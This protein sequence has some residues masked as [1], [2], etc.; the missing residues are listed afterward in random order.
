MTNNAY[1]TIDKTDK[2]VSGGARPARWG[3]ALIIGLSFIAALALVVCATPIFKLTDIQ[4]SGN[5]YYKKSAIVDKS[6]LRLGQNGL[7]ALRGYNPIKIFSL[8][9]AAAEQSVLA[10]CPYVKTVQARYV[11]PKSVHIE[12]EERVKSVVVPY[13]NSALL[14]DDEGVVVDIARDCGEPGLPVVNGLPVSQ[15]NV[16]KQLR[17]ED[18]AKVNALL[19]VISALKQADRDSE[20][21]LSPSVT[22]IDLADPKNIAL[23]LGER[24]RINLGDGAELYYKVSVAK[25]I[26]SNGISG[27]E[28]GTIN[29]YDGARPVFM[30]G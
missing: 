26:I 28:S 24:L 7:Y 30:P 11:A 12:V 23:I 3:A 15:Y 22:G 27:D 9:C 4:V 16:G 8:R 2:P 6:G 14:I 17:S 21:A 5:S 19:M 20:E 10:A 18:G 25:E 1:G 29:F 13:H